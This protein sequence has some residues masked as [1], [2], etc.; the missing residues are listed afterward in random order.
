MPRY[1]VIVPALIEINIDHLS[2]IDQNDIANL[3]LQHFLLTNLT[4]KMER[5]LIACDWHKMKRVK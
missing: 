2:D 3:G 4:K 5:V 1:I